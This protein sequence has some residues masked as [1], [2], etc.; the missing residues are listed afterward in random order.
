MRNYPVTKLFRATRLLTLLIVSPI[1]MTFQ[2]CT[3]LTEVPTSSITPDNFYRNEAEVLG[4]LASVYST[5]RSTLD[6]Y[7][8]LTQVSTDE[9]IVPTRGSDWY[10]NGRWLEID[11]QS[12]TVGSAVGL[13]DINGA[14]NNLFQGV[15]RAN[16]VLG[17]IENVSVTNKAVIQ[18][19]LRTL[20]AFYYYLLMDMFGGV[21]I[22]ETTEIGASPQATR[23]QVFAFIE[24]E[25]NAARAVLP[26]SWPAASHGRF[27]SGVADAILA[28]MY[29]N[30][31]VFTGT[32]S[33]TG[34]TPGAARWADAVTAA[35]RILN[36]P[37]YSLATD[38]RSNFRAD[39]NTST[40]N[41]LVVKMSN[42]PDLGMNFV[43]RALHYAQFNPSPW[44]GFATIAEVYNA[45][46]AADVRRQIF[47]VGLQ[48]NQDP[49]SATFGQPVND[50]AGNP[51]IFTT[52]IAD[53]TQAT[54]GEGARILKWPADP[55][56][57]QQEN[58]NDFAYF[59]LGEIYLIKAEALNEQ[60]QTAAA[61]AL[62]NTI[63]A[64]AFEPDQPLAAL[65]Q[66]QLRDAIFNE[67][68]FELTAEAKRRQDLIRA[69]RY[70]SATYFNNAA[71]RPPYKILMP[72]PRAQ[73]ET[74]SNLAQNAGY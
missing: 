48:T 66:A 36:S 50:R 72:I 37:Q 73:L 51:L 25:L 20:R 65:T 7:Y 8:N 22:V 24:T 15:A 43:M 31:Q 13:Q 49:K 2:A 41:I 45:F 29:V 74:N 5:L 47:L 30:A 11:R 26:A 54:E 44:N 71:A 60:G 56:H 1:L 39:N 9:H 58:G 52:S 27:T 46:N 64:R 38:W 59:R 3:D 35:D 61:L 57:V 69:G 4:G 19:E 32:V 40:E 18:A 12:W 62:V 28:S 17:A 55:N 33:T 42:Q 6:D 53:P 21:P 63:R 70:T 10:D 67:R 23:A 68:L 14:W 34:L 16:V